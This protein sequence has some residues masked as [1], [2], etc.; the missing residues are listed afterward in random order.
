MELLNSFQQ[1]LRAA[2]DR[3]PD[4]SAMRLFTPKTLSAIALASQ[5]V[6]NLKAEKT[7]FDVFQFVDPLIG[8]SEGGHV[9][10]GATLPF[11]M[12]KAV[13]DVNDPDEKQGGF[14]SGDSDITGFSHMHDSGTGG[15]CCFGIKIKHLANL[16]RHHHWEISHSFHRLAVLET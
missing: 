10:P 1:P 2:V 6:L 4:W 11:G 3:L 9:F 13:A 15:V 16:P 7:A 5:S 14:A 8:T 12:A